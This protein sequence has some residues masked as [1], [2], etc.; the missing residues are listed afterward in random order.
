MKILCCF[1]DFSDPSN[2]QQYNIFFNTFKVL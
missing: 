2:E 1:A